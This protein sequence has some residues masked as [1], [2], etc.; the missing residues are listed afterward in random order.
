[1]HIQS[2]LWT[3]DQK[4]RAC[5]GEDD[6]LRRKFSALHHQCCPPSVSAPFLRTAVLSTASTR[7]VSPCLGTIHRQ[8]L[9]RF[10]CPNAVY[11]HCPPR[12][13]MP[14]CC[15]PLV[16]SAPL[17]R[18]SVLST[19]SVRSVSPCVVHRQCPF[20]SFVPHCCPPSV[21]AP[22][23]HAQC[24]SPSLPAPLLRALVLSY[25]LSSSVPQC[26][27]PSVSAPFFRVLKLT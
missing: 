18:A 14:W 17:L 19:V 10:L 11:R 16:L 25:P 5:G 8:C 13:S 1:M 4:G 21:P 23:L 27:P 24:C 20:R 15:P 3:G 7:S 2:A 9:L 12:F 6:L 22:F 26:C